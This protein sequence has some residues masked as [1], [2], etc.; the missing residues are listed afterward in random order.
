MS[1]KKSKIPKINKKS[2]GS[3]QLRR[4]RILV[5]NGVNLDLL[6][7][8][9]PEHYGLDGLGE[10]EQKLNEFAVQLHGLWPHMVFDLS[11]FQ[12]NDERV[13][14]EHFDQGWDGVLLNAGAWTHTSLA[15][16]DRLAALRLPFVEVHLSNLARRED[17]RHKSYTAAQSLGV[18]YGFGTDSYLT[19][20]VGLLLQLQK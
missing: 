17:F 12:S 1:Q 15:L 8:R 19:G 4:F 5:A 2:A 9:D 16:A 10:I 18:V 13:F 20:L 7:Q 6:G 3:E 11:F 14:L